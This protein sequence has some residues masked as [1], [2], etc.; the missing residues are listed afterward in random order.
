MMINEEAIPILC[1][2]SYC[3]T[4]QMWG[5]REAAVKQRKLMSAWRRLPYRALFVLQKST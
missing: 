2:F 4:E 5:T 3:L 1:N